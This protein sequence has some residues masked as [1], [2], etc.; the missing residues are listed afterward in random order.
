M[1][2]INRT[3]MKKRYLLGAFLLFLT[4]SAV[5]AQEQL[6]LRDRGNL[7][8][9][10]YEYAR[11]AA[12]FSTLASADKARYADLVR[13]GE[14]YFQMRDFAQAAQ[15][16]ARAVAH[17]EV[18]A[19]DILRYADALKASGQYAAAKS[20][21]ER[22][23]KLSQSGLEDVTLR[24]AGADSALNWI[25]HPTAHVLQNES[26]INTQGSEF[27]ISLIG[28][29]LYYTGE[30]VNHADDY[31]WTGRPFLKLHRTNRTDGVL[32]SATL[33]GNDL[34]APDF[35]VGPAA[36]PDG[37]KTL[38]VTR[39]YVGSDMG[40]ER[41]GIRTY[42]THRLEIYVYTQQQGE[43]VGSPFEHNDPSGF[44][45]G[46]ATFSPD[47]RTMYF[48]SDPPGGQ[49]GV[50]IL[51]SERQG[52]AWSTPQNAGPLINTAGDELFPQVDAEGVLY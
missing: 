51:F 45:V 1:I 22:Y 27:S 13:A 44:S 18:T 25:N 6:S 39:T 29:D 14:S 12:V 33:V 48:V 52:N 36:S 8:F 41:E 19:A 21:Y 15:W 7:H 50:D 37:G 31:G 10:R 46:H 11:A 42:R 16:Y 9:E 43:W 28:Q 17:E 30:P 20:Q 34:N 24:I 35:H 2:E 5:F 38:Y 26:A 3:I 4:S 40:K 32:G 47:G 23:S 49:G